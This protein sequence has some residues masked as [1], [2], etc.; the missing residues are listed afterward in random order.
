MTLKEILEE[1][2]EHNSYPPRGSVL[3]GN[4]VLVDERDIDTLR[5]GTRFVNVYQR[6]DE[7]VAVEDVQPAT[8]VQDWG[9][10][11]PP[12]IYEVEPVTETSTVTHYNKKE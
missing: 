12:E 1:W 4:V 9:D 8:E 3:D 2:Y 7:F 11:G 5:W 10:Y 6:A